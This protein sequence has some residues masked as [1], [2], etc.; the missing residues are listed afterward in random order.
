[1]PE[2]ERQVWPKHKSSP[3]FAFIAIAREQ[4]KDTVNV[5]QGFGIGPDAVG[6]VDRA[7]QKALVQKS[8][9][10]CSGFLFCLDRRPVRD[11]LKT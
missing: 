9:K 11:H 5:Y 2:L 10:R 8:P 7:T 3:H 6:E 4:D 1:M